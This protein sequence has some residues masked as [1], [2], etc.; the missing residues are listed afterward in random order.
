LGICLTAKSIWAKG[1]VMKTKMVSALLVL[2]CL[3]LV[4]ETEHEIKVTGYAIGEFAVKGNV[5]R[6]LERVSALISSLRP[7]GSQ[8]EFSII[9][10]ADQAGTSARNDQLGRSRAEE[11]KAFLSVKFPDARTVA[12]TKGDEMDARAVVVKWKFVSAHASP[13][14]STPKTS[15]WLWQAVLSGGSVMLLIVVVV[16]FVLVVF[17]GSKKKAS[18]ETAEVPEPPTIPALAVAETSEMRLVQVE[19][20]GERYSVPVVR[21]DGVWHTPFQTQIDPTKAIFRKEFRD[22]A[23]AVKSCVKNQPYYASVIEKLIAEGTIRRTR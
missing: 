4:A 12:M 19:I 10:C 8:I 21:K 7:P 15:T 23:N 13:A 3:A 17:F 5:E 9:G 22:A 11:V 1:D 20:N 14:Q 16:G 2:G 6:Q 18:R